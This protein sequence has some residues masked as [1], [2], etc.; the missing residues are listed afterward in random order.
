M[1]FIRRLFASGSG[2]HGGVEEHARL[3]RERHKAEAM[4]AGLGWLSSGL[5]KDEVRQVYES[6]LHSF[7]GQAAHSNMHL[8]G[9]V[10]SRAIDVS[11]VKASPWLVNAMAYPDHF[12]TPKNYADMLYG[13]SGDEWP[14]ALTE[15]TR[16]DVACLATRLMCDLIFVI[17]PETVS[18]QSGRSVMSAPMS[19]EELGGEGATLPLVP[20]T[21]AM[22]PLRVFNEPCPRTLLGCVGVPANKIRQE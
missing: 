7:T 16:S 13:A 5:T 19:V 22:N 10:V 18:L 20:T 15:Q 4:Q 1:A 21:T 3:L 8:R 2:G 11:L 14:D 17:K 12:I 9:S 6:V